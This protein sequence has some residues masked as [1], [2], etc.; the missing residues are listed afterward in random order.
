MTSRDHVALET[1]KKRQAERRV[2]VERDA[3]LTSR[4][5][6][7]SQSQF[8]GGSAKRNMSFVPIVNTRL[9][10]YSERPRR[11]S[12]TASPSHLVIER[13]CHSL[14]ASPSKKLGSSPVS[15]L[16]NSL[17][18]RKPK[19]HDRDS[20]DEDLNNLPT[21]TPGVQRSKNIDIPRPILKV[22]NSHNG[23]QQSTYESDESVEDTEASPQSEGRSPRLR[24]VSIN[25][26][27]EV[28][29]MEDNTTFQTALVD[30]PES[31]PLV[32]T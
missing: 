20:F 29:R 13:R 24:S 8:T 27:V 9:N 5:C 10:V 3:M 4:C 16:L 25:E 1:L 26:V 22:P 28:L 21:P 7:R 30:H 11:H 6:P 14:S 31:L 17:L 32:P 15:S 23:S 18:K 12:A 2:A 19:N